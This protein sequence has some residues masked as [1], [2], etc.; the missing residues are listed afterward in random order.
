[1]SL[2][3]NHEGYWTRFVW[4]GQQKYKGEVYKDTLIPERKVDD[5][6]KG[7]TFNL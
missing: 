1:M 2:S 7:N 4:Y 5:K 6:Q 3:L